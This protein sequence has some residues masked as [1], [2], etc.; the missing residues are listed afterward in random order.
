MEPTKEPNKSLGIAF[1]SIEEAMNELTTLAEQEKDI[2]TRRTQIASHL[3]EITK[4]VLE[5]KELINN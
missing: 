4:K 2:Q 5:A 3:E 1:R